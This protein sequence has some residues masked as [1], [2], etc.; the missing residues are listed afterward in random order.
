MI[1]MIL[2]LS[3]KTVFVQRER[4]GIVDAL[5]AVKKGDY[6][7]ET[8]DADDNEDDDVED[9]SPHRPSMREIKKFTKKQL[10]EHVVEALELEKKE[11]QRML[12][13]VQRYALSWMW[14]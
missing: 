8:E 1:I 11:Y 13:E 12:D 2:K 6:E 10:L 9:D 7:D 5:C 4:E 14:K 3:W